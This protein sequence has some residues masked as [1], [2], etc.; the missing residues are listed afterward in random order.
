MMDDLAPPLSSSSTVVV[1]VRAAPDETERRRN[2][3]AA[4]AALAFQDLERTRYRIVVVEQDAEARLAD[5][6]PLADRYVFAYNP[7]PYN[8]SWG[9]NVG[10]VLAGPAAGALCLLDADLLV[11]PDFL[12]RGLAALRGGARALL[13][14]REVLYLDGEATRRAIAERLAAPGAA[15]DPARLTG[16]RFTSSQG[17]A[18][19][20]DAALYHAVGGYDERF[21]GWGCEDREI[22]R[23]LERAA[24]TLPRLDG[25]LLHLDHPR[26]DESGEAT[27]ANA[28]L[29]ARLRRGRAEEAP[30]GP[31]GDPDRYS[32]D[33]I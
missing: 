21:R 13:P 23:R 5:L 3:R 31:I 11:P 19:W 4:L 8:R 30:A 2:A 16:R 25:C 17:G 24:G 29:W 15:P 20:V 7:G 26:P 32:P 6:A 10:A 14:Y 28:Q 1:G 9:F 27:R 33:R 12:S 18:L 22:C